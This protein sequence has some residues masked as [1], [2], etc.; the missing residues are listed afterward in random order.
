MLLEK[1]LA[2]HGCSYEVTVLQLGH[3]MTV[4]LSKACACQ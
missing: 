1:A 4:I 3:S 2:S